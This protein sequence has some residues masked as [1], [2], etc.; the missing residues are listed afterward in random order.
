VPS[1]DIYLTGA[2]HPTVFD[3]KSLLPERMMQIAASLTPDVVPPMVRLRVEEESFS[4][5]AGL[6][7][8]SEALFDTASAI[9]R[10]WRSEAWQ[11]HMTVT[12]EATKDPNGRPLTFS[13]VLLRGDPDHVR[14]EPF[15]EGRRARLTFEW[16]ERP[17]P[18]P[19]Q[20]GTVSSA[21]PQAS[22]IDIGVFASNGAQDSA[23]A[24]ISVSLPTHQLRQYEPEPDGAMR[25]VSIDYDANSRKASYDSMLYWSA[26]W[27]DRFLYD[28]T[29]RLAGWQRTEADGNRIE[30]AADGRRKDGSSVT[31]EV[32][33]NYRRSELVATSDTPA[34][35]G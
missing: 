6:A 9:A 24:F 15:D 20:A 32:W 7:G 29:G 8:E 14:I 27:S 23:P 16:Q 21:P 18:Q 2:A 30:F 11:Q 13:W 26:P 25:L 5:Q 31:Y 10:L 1:R 17:V 34:D 4:P 22:R 35:P 33:R 28:E 3:G 19:P 12:A